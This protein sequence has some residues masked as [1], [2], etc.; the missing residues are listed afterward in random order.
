M[1]TVYVLFW[2]TVALE[3]GFLVAYIAGWRLGSGLAVLAGYCSI[4]ALALMALG[5]PGWRVLL[6]TAAAI[7]L[8]WGADAVRRHRG[9]SIAD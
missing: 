6:I 4:G 8:G 7:G 2:C 9:L 3:F 5:E 1:E